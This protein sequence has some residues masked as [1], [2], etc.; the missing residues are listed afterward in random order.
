MFVVAVVVAADVA[1]A[2]VVVVVVD[3]VVV[4]GVPFVAT[5][6]GI[7]LKELFPEVASLD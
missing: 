7:F 2:D 6:V 4:V 3:V 5:K 1:V